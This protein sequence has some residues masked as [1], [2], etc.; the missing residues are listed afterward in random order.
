MRSFCVPNHICRKVVA[1]LGI[2]GSNIDVMGKVNRF[3][4]SK[5]PTIDI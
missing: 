1:L 3:Q 5:R 2:K 4:L